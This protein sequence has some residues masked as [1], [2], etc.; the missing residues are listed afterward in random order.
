MIVFSMR[1][2]LPDR[3][4]EISRIGRQKSCPENN[5]G[6][7]S[8]EVVPHP[9][10]GRA[11]RPAFASRLNI[12]THRKSI[13][14][15]GF[16]SDALTGEPVITIS[17]INSNPGASTSNG[18]IISGKSTNAGNNGSTKNGNARNSREWNSFFFIAQTPFPLNIKPKICSFFGDIVQYLSWVALN[19]DIH[20]KWARLGF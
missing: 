6:F 14:Q 7:A 12:L 15:D 17:A 18:G 19:R 4:N 8:A 3:I 9:R 5:A 20:V 10:N 11:I 13:L 16:L 1:G 2:N